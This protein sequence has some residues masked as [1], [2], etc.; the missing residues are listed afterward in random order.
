MLFGASMKIFRNEKIGIIKSLLDA[1][2]MGIDAACYL[3]RECG[4]DVLISP[5]HV[6]AAFDNIG[7]V[8][9]QEIIIKWLT[10]NEIV[11]IGMT[12]RLDPQDAI[13][14]FG[15]FF[16]MLESSEL[17]GSK[18]IIRNVYFAGLQPVCQYIN[19]EYRGRVI[20]FCGGETTEETLTLFGVPD[21][22]IDTSVVSGSKYDK[23]LYDFGKKVIEDEKYKQIVP[24]HATKYKKYGT[25]YDTLEERLYHVLYPFQQPLIRAHAGP[26]DSGLSRRECVEQFLRWCKIMASSGYLDILSVGASQLSQSKFGASWDGLSNGGGVPVNSSDEYRE[27]WESAN[28]MLVRTYSGTKNV[29]IMANIYEDTINMA[30]HALSL[31]WFN[32]LDGR[33]DNSLYNNLKEHID[34]IDYIASVGKPF[35]A[36][37]SHHFAFRGCDD[38]TY[39]VSAF[40][41]AKLAKKRGIK[42][43]VL[44]NMLNTPR[45][46]WGVQD[47]AKSRVL[48]KL[49]SE[50]KDDTFNI[51]LQTRAGLDYFKPD[52]YE[53]KVQLAAV[54]A[55][56]DDIEP[57]N[58]YS[59]GIIHVVSYS[60]ALHLATPDIIDE[61]IKI[62]RE[63]LN[64]YRALK[65]IDGIVDM[66]EGDI[67]ERSILLEKSARSIIGEMERN[68][69]NLYSPEGFYLA[70]VSGWFPVPGLWNKSD[71]F[72]QA[73]DWEVRIFDGGRYLSEKNI[74][75]SDDIRINR[76][77]SNLDEAKYKLKSI[78]GVTV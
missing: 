1:H 16:H 12:Y 17:I 7:S 25:F 30:W 10:E 41:T 36:N 8:E 35:E 14:K 70:F 75:L 74:I 39:I 76:C 21:E 4:Y 62:T 38:V 58:V 29:K 42:T 72:E 5:T 13:R 64:S 26:Y 20:T 40:L 49:V 48:I 27:I 60:E 9:Q 33:G 15:I 19:S 11:H 57:A 23:K 31:W 68:I 47:L 28:P 55:L 32:E 37:V 22:Y 45:S 65:K 24:L 53:A 44:Q 34:T 66:Y 51:V 46:T 3:L 71:E 69:S 56:M 50:L 2:T 54:T 77:V 61:S 63:A 6:S 18:N 67:F 78:H 43:F 73:R 59:P 52:I